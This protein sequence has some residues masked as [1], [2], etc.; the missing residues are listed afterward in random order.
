MSQIPNDFIIL[1]VHSYSCMYTPSD[2]LIKFHCDV[3]GGRNP[4]LIPVIF[5]V[6]PVDGSGND[7]W[8]YFGDCSIRNSSSCSCFCNEVGDSGRV[9]LIAVEYAQSTATFDGHSQTVV[10]P[11]SP[12]MVNGEAGGVNNGTG[13]DSSLSDPFACSSPSSC[14]SISTSYSS[15]DDEASRSMPLICANEGWAGS[16]RSKRGSSGSV[17]SASRWASP[18]SIFWSNVDKD[19]LNLIRCLLGESPFSPLSIA[20]SI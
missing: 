8:R 5:G 13:S 20:E 16:P 6:K 19:S 4:T 2:K 17:T 11:L 15:S 9:S 1:L 7:F 10:S 12:W 14:L 3:V 18:F